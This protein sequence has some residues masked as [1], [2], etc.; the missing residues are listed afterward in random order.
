MAAIAAWTPLATSYRLV[1]D[2]V[3]TGTNDLN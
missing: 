1:M 2:T 3:A